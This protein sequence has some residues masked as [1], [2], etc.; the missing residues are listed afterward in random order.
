LSKTVG[1]T[2]VRYETALRRRENTMQLPPSPAVLAA[3]PLSRDPG[4]LKSGGE[5]SIDQP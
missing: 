2:E 3:G 4:Q 5:V 1:S